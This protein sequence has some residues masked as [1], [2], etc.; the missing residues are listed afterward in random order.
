MAWLHTLSPFV[1][2]FTDDFGI[3]WYGLAYLAGFGVAYLLLR[4]LAKRE[5][6]AIPYERVGDALVWFIGGALVGG[7]L[8]YALVYD[9]ALF[10]RFTDHF[11]WWGLFAI[12]QGGMASHGGMVGVIIAGL[13]VCRWGLRGPPP[14]RA[15]LSPGSAFMHVCDV[16][17]FICP[18]GLFFGRL[19]NFVNGELLGAIV[20][21]PGEKAPW[22][23]VQ[24][25]QEL[26]LWSAD[27]HPVITSPGN[28]LVQTPEQWRQ[29]LELADRLAPANTEKGLAEGIHRLAHEAWAHP[30]LHDKLR[31]LVSSRH[32]SQLYQ[33]AAEGLVLAAVLWIVWARPR[34]PGVVGC[35][36]L[37]S[38][39]VLRILT[40]LIRLPDSQFAE[41]RPLGLSRGQWL[42]VAMVA[43]GAVVLVYAARRVAPRLGGWRRAKAHSA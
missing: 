31:L 7:R 3:R 18:A 24:Y 26:E 41:G 4:W 35:W 17:A 15:R 33:A 27:P 12:N 38:Y 43:A 28:Q 25:P 14:E 29:V 16:V 30:E 20:A 21:K 42:S 1:L 11:P 36:F 22:W 23:A 5:L 40:E 39:G 19:A 32:P 13:I 6:I 9:P 37:I 10:V 8:G 2:R 34:K